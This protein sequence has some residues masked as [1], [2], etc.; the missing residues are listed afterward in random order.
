MIGKHP[1]V[2]TAIGYLPNHFNLELFHLSFNVYDAPVDIAA[3]GFRA[4]AGSWMFQWKWN[5]SPGYVFT[6]RLTA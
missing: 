2:S 6:D 3:I 5:S 4:S 1:A